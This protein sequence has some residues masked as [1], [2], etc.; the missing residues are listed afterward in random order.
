MFPPV[1]L[2]GEDAG[3]QPGQ[4]GNGAEG[5]GPMMPDDLPAFLM[6]QWLEFLATLSKPR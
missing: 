1:L 2:A 6:R 4:G 3:A 5:Q